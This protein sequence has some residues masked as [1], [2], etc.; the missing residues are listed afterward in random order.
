LRSP[1]RPD[2]DLCALRAARPLARDVRGVPAHR[3]VAGTARPAATLL[4]RHDQRVPHP[5]QRSTT[6]T[7]VGSPPSRPA[8]SWWA[9]APARLHHLQPDPALTQLRAQGDQV[10]HGAAEPI[11]PGHHQHI[12][13]PQDPQA[14]SSFG[15]DAWRRWRGRHGCSPGRRRPAAGRRFGGPG[16]A[17]RWRPARTRPASVDKNPDHG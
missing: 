5:R 2:Y 10:Q 13:V 16:S 4:S 1:R 12:P 6:A 17:R 8:W 7:G 11:Q 14:R 15:R 9:T 3:V